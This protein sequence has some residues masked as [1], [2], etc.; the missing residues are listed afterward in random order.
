M[1]KRYTPHANIKWALAMQ[2]VLFKT[3][4]IQK[5]DNLSNFRIEYNMGDNPYIDTLQKL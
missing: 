1:G 4:F 5:F 2:A 3:N